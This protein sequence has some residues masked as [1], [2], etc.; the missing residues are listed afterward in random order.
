MV[1]SIRTQKE[2][3]PMQDD[4]YLKRFVELLQIQTRIGFNLQNVL[5]ADE[6][7]SISNKQILNIINI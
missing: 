3:G 6:C 1:P 7:H 5:Q 4:A 2:S